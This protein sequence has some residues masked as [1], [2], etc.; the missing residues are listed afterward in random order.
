VLAVAQLKTKQQTQINNT[1]TKAKILA[2]N[3]PGSKTDRQNR[4][5]PTSP[6]RHPAGKKK[7]QGLEADAPGTSH[8]PLLPQASRPYGEAHAT[9]LPVT[10]AHW[11]CIS[12]CSRT[13]FSQ[14]LCPRHAAY[15]SC[16]GRTFLIPERPQVRLRPPLIPFRTYRSSSIVWP[17]L[18]LTSFPFGK[19]QEHERQV[20]ELLYKRSGQDSR[21]AKTGKGFLP[22]AKHCHS[23]AQTPSG[24]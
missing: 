5:T 20:V 15:L 1:C 24:L 10:S 2:E 12:S 4:Q 3:S 17:G 23:L 16:L 13:S 18:H 14:S 8:C 21:T 6:Q 11:R 7:L 9:Y 19:C 22:L